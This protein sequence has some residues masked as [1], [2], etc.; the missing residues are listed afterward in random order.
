MKI[1]IVYESR[2]GRTR[3]AALQMGELV[4]A[5][6]HECS[7]TSVEETNP[8]EVAGADAICVGCWVKGLFFILQHPSEAATDFIDRLGPL[9]GRPAAVFCTYLTAAGTT[10]SQIAERLSARGANVTGRFKS[11]R[12]RAPKGFQA[13]VQNLEAAG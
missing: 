10:L 7:V 11:R 12:S 9:E 6:G 3:K 1:A 5:A 13:W 4:R 8:A 2:T